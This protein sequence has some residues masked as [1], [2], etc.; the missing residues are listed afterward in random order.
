MAITFNNIDIFIM[1][2][3]KKYAINI[4]ISLAV[5]LTGNPEAGLV[6]GQ[7]FIKTLNPKSLSSRWTIII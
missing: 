2:T 5:Q 3:R 6:I 4:H 7:P 1:F